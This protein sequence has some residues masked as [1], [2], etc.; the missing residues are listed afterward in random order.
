MAVARRADRFLCGAG[1][2]FDGIS[3]VMLTMRVIQPTIVLMVAALYL[4]LQIVT[5]APQQMTA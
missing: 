4:F 1:L 2:F 5:F 3:M